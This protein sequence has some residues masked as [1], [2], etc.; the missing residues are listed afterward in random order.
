MV[1]QWNDL[2]AGDV[3]NY[4]RKADDAMQL[5]A[6]LK[7]DV[8]SAFAGANP[9]R[10]D[11]ALNAIYDRFAEIA[12]DLQKLNAD[13][14]AIVQ[15]I[16]KTDTAFADTEKSIADRAEQIALHSAP[17]YDDPSSDDRYMNWKDMQIDVPILM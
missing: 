17:T 4:L 3:L 6:R 11:E 1:I 9:D 2:A 14:A 7:S 16:Q 12:G 13:I 5:C 15:A 8:E 10:E